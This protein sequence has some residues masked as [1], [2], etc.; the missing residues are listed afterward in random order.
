VPS[1]EIRVKQQ[2]R[3]QSCEYISGSGEQCSIVSSIAID[4]LACFHQRQSVRSVLIAPPA[5]PMNVA[6]AVR[7][8]VSP[9]RRERDAPAGGGPPGGGPSSAAVKARFLRPSDDFGM[10]APATRRK[11]RSSAEP[12][13]RSLRPGSASRRQSAV[14][15]P[16]VVWR[17]DPQILFRWLRAAIDPRHSHVLVNTAQLGLMTSNGNAVA[18]RSDLA[19]PVCPKI[20]PAP[21]FPDRPVACRF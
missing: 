3:N 7:T 6:A 12:R 17:H 16:A 8:C 13:P 1:G 20:R 2:E 4:N 15:R 18:A 19:L 10:G 21:T 9:P 14:W 5:A 11:A